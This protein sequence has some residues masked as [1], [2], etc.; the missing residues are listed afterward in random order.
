MAPGAGGS[1]SGGWR[2]AASES[3]VILTARRPSPRGLPPACGTPSVWCFV[4]P[5]APFHH[6][7]CTHAL[8]AGKHSASDGQ[9]KAVRPLN[10]V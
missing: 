6:A 5:L 4:L 10:P 7:L 1:D 2:A 8:A 9:A 3:V